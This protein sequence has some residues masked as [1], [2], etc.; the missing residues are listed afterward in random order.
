MRLDWKILM[1]ETKTKAKKDNFVMKK[2]FGLIFIFLFLA[3]AKNV[4]AYQINSV[5][6]QNENVQISNPEISQN[7]FDELKGQ[8]RDY[9]IN[10]PTDFNLHVNILVP[11]TANSQGEYSAKIFLENGN[12]EQ[13]IAVLDGGTF[14]WKETYDSFTRDY[15]LKGPEFSK[16]VL[17]GKYKIEIFSKDNKGEY[18]LAIGQKEFYDAN[19]VLNIFWQLPL[20]KISFL[21]TSVLQFFLTPFGIGLIGIIGAFLIFL[22]LIYFFVGAVKEF[23]K[24]N[25]AKTLLLTSSGMQM[26]EEIVKLLTKPAYDIT[27]ASVS[28]AKKDLDV[29]KDEMGFNIEEIDIEGKTESQILKLLELKDIIFVGGENTFYLLG[30]MRKC[31]FEKVIKKLLKSGKVY[32]G[33]GAGSIVAGKTIK[34]AGWFGDENAIKMKNLKGLNLVPFDIFVHYTPE[35]AEVIKQK[36]K[37]PRKRK[38][39]LRIL[40]DSQAILVQGKETDLIGEGEAIII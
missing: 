12:A 17:A 7:F 28:A 32:I 14:N 36:I 15:Y 31:N 35:C 40:T 6:L 4:F 34:T 38:K 20:L 19:S 2:I 9:F 24:H 18:I 8:P 23:I 26:K 5:Y 27:V 21:K 10:S 39:Q 3:A 37:N 29:M 30:A 11:E 33:A 22:A 1:C 25:Q 13:Q 16:Q